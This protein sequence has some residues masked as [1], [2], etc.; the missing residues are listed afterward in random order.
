MGGAAGKTGGY[1]DPVFDPKGKVISG[2]GASSGLKSFDFN[3]SSGAFK[4]QTQDK[5]GMTGRLDYAKVLDPYHKTT[6][7]DTFSALAMTWDPTFDLKQWESDSINGNRFADTSKDLQAS[8]YANRANDLEVMARTLKNS[9]DSV[10]T[11]SNGVTLYSADEKKAAAKLMADSLD[12]SALD[13]QGYFYN[14]YTNN[15]SKPQYTDEQYK[16]YVQQLKTYGGAAAGT[17]PI[18][19]ETA[20][21][22]ETLAPSPST[23]MGISAAEG[24]DLTEA[25]KLLRAKS[26]SSSTILNG[27]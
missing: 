11:L 22:E 18:D 19:G 27:A 15:I 1:S 14:G 5:Y 25:E 3:S 9:P 24:Q 21:P 13:S 23:L 20:A 6:E 17:D 4:Y 16:E 2:G 8:N 26:S 12:K 7:N 10:I